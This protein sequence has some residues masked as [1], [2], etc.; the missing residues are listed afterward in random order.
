MFNKTI[1]TM[2]AV[3]MFLLVNVVVNCSPNINN[4][5]P[6]IRGGLIKVCFNNTHGLQTLGYM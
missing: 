3:V 1:L 2:N 4:T 6:H 5:K